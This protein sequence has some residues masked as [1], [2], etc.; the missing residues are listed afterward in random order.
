MGE[1]TREKDVLGAEEGDEGAGDE[2]DSSE[3]GLSRRA[4]RAK[5]RA[6]SDIAEAVSLA[7]RE[8][9]K[10]EA[11][12]VRSQELADSLAEAEAKAKEASKRTEEFLENVGQLAK[13]VQE[14][15]DLE[16]FERQT[17]ESDLNQLLDRIVRKE[18]EKKTAGEEGNEGEGEESLDGEMDL[19]PFSPVP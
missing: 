6:E 16:E 8:R 11:E 3:A 15:R 14:A 2:A 12:R 9:A 4:Q 18:E 1:R 5:A 17:R 13:R 7:E 19:G 10:K